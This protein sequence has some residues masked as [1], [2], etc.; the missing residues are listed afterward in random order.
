MDW[1]RPEVWDRVYREL[2]KW[3]IIRFNAKEQ[4]ETE[5]LLGG[6]MMGICG[7]VLGHCMIRGLT[8]GAGGSHGGERWGRIR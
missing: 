5:W 2:V 6:G 7:E 8:D 4:W 3:K 1:R